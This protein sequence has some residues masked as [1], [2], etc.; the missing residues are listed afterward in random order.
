MQVSSNILIFLFVIIIV[1]LPVK[2]QF[3]VNVDA[4]LVKHNIEINNFGDNYY[5]QTTPGLINVGVLAKS[6]NNR[7]NVDFISQSGRLKPMIEEIDYYDTHF[8]D[9]T[10]HE[11]GVEYLKKVEEP[12][13]RLDVFLGLGHK[14]QLSNYTKRIESKFIESRADF[15]ESVVFNLSILGAIEYA[16]EEKLIHAKAGVGVLS[17]RFTKEEN[18]YT[19]KNFIGIGPSLLFQLES[20]I[21]VQIPIASRIFLRPEY[22]FRYYKYETYSEMKA[23]QQYFLLGGVFQL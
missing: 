22:S 10:H 16:F 20:R 9:V 15:E 23:L 14:A 17:Y 1:Q 6:E 3:Y 19:D 5:E 13:N 18:W 4:G 7:W 8:V 21:Y 2:A 12:S 11:L